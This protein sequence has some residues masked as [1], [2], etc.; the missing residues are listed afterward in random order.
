MR[1]ARHQAGILADAAGVK[2]GRLLQVERPDQPAMARRSGQGD[3]DLPIEPGTR[4]LR[5]AVEATYAIE[6]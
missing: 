1:D 5:K 2:L 4:T 3:L 6:P